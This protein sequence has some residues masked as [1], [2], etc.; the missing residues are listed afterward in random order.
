M[1]TKDLK[2]KSIF[3]DVYS[4]YY[5]KKFELNKTLFEIGTIDDFI[6]V[7]RTSDGGVVWVFPQSWQD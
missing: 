3:E 2:Y 4:N 6:A 5:K 1:T 7:S